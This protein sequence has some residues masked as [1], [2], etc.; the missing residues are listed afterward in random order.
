METRIQAVYVVIEGEHLEK[1][2]YRRV[3]TGFV[4]RDQ[5]MTILLDAVPLSGR[6]YVR[7]TPSRHETTRTA[8]A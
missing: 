4:N 8:P 3:G 2:I 7:A 1:P 6:L 5:S